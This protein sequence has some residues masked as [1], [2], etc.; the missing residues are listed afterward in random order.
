MLRRPRAEK[1]YS[2]SSFEEIKM[3]RIPKKQLRLPVFQLLVCVLLGCSP[4]LAE[5]RVAL[6]IGNSAYLN[7][8]RLTNPRNDANDIAAALQRMG[9]ETIVGLDLDKRGMDEAS[10]RFARAVRDADVALY[11]YSGH[12]MQFGGVNYLMPV[13]AE[14][15]DE[16]DLRM[17]SRVDDAVVDLQQARNLRIMVLDSCRD[18]PLAEEL[19]RS[20]GTTRGAGIQRGLARID[21]PQGM[22][23]A[24]ST[25]AG[26]TAADGNGRNSPYTSAFLRNV[27]TPEEIGTIFRRI[28]ADVY[29]NTKRSQLP[30]LSLS[31][32]GEFYLKGRPG[33]AAQPAQTSD[34]APLQQGK[35]PE[36]Q[37]TNVAVATPVEIPPTPT[38]HPVTDA[39]GGRWVVSWGNN[40]KNA[41]SLNIQ[42]GK[43]SGAYT[44]DSKDSCP[45]T[46]TFKENTRDLLL[47]VACPRWSIEMQGSASTDLSA[48]SGSYRAYGNASGAFAMRRK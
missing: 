12:A 29:E 33:I 4:A 8:P 16:A 3:W 41:L 47:H 46:G 30:E 10:I 14:L 35:E 44:N 13:D 43:V 6:V 15:K 40:T 32:I 23:V 48:V 1:W 17:M 34:A 5:K 9:F 19:K 11:Y 26:R 42:N 38:P 18:N 22:I 36:R 37:P 20:I 25:Q 24:Y 21:S 2:R 31:L 7:A 28:S 39:L 27:E 45:T